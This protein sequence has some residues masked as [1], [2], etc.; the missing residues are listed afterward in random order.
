MG[1]RPKERLKVGGVMCDRGRS[2]LE[3]PVRVVVH[4]GGNCAELFIQ[5]VFKLLHGFGE[6]FFD[7]GKVSVCGI[8]HGLDFVCYRLSYGCLC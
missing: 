8:A 7:E 2:R 3:P 6:V 4:G 5:L 1:N